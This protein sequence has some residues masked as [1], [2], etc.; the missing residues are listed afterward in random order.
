MKTSSRKS[1]PVADHER[2]TAELSTGQLVIG[3]SILLMMGLACFL[4][5]VVVGKFDPSLNPDLARQAQPVR[6]TI[7][8]PLPTD[9]QTTSSANSTERES[10]VQITPPPEL[11]IPRETEPRGARSAASTPTDTTQKGVASPETQTE[12]SAP[13]PATQNEKP[14]E[15]PKK[16]ADV[17]R[18]R[19]TK[20]PAKL[21]DP[22]ST[23]LKP[24]PSVSSSFAVQ[25]AAFQTRQRAEVLK[26]DL[27]AQS[28]Y[29]ARIVSSASGRLFKVVVGSY[30]DRQSVNKVR[31]DLKRNFNFADCFVT[32]L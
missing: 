24:S 17:P 26:R 8:A 7:P 2:Y 15:T 31:D 29:K 32:S 20:A 13:K 22:K 6:A 5:G 27:E 4:M 14:L 10:R 23:P 21:S 12:R 3:M 18:E 30:A 25:I 16:G 1:K 9:R 19:V 11:R 28:P